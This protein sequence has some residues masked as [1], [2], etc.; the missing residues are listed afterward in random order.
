MRESKISSIDCLRASPKT[1]PCL[2]R[3][4][5]KKLAWWGYPTVKTFDAM[6]S[7]FVIIPAC[8]RQTDRQTD[9]HLAAAKSAPCIRSARYKAVQIRYVTCLR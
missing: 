8:D 5:V 1:A 7:R 2:A 4:G 6:F 3:R 9:R